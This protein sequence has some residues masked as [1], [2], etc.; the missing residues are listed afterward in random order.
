MDKK[1]IEEILREIIGKHLENIQPEKI[2]INNEL[3]DLG[4]DSLSFSLILAD[5]E[6]SFDFIIPGSDILKLKTLAAAI[7]YVDEHIAK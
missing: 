2:D 4:V 7:D 1:Q 3:A 6:D 5:M